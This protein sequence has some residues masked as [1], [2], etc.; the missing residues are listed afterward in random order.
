[1]RRLSG[2][3]SL[4]LACLPG[5]AWSHCS[6]VLEVP[7]AP[8]G[9]AVTA[10]D[11]KVGG[12]YPELLRNL[13]DE[14][15]CEMNFTLVPRARQE[16]LFENGQA[17]L[18]VPARRSP[19]RDQSGE[20]IPLIKSR[21]MFVSLHALPNEVHSITELLKR[22]ELRVVLVRGYDYGSAY[23]ALIKVLEAQGRLLW[24]TDPI[25]VIRSL[26]AGMAEL[27]ILT[28][29]VLTGAMRADGKYSAQIDQLHYQS[30][31]ELPWG[32]SGVYIS[33]KSS[34]SEADRQQLRQWLHHLGKSGAT[35]RAFQRY[36]PEETLSQT[37]RPY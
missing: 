18:L 3:A 19:K 7:V 24:S 17:D 26:E 9:L 6:R 16:Y 21:V 20:F 35:W 36:Y 12:I 14:P 11:G 37:I 13:A 30:V 5:F 29:T 2:L 23:L 4:V 28:P 25:S 34:L 1:M 32:D 10:S 22:H 8:I 27:T 31:D 15:G 33:K